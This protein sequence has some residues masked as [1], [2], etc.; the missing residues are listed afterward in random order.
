MSKE[1]Q[2]LRTKAISNIVTRDV[3]RDVQM[4]TLERIAMALKNSYGPDGSTTTLRVGDDTKNTGITGYTK[5]GHRILSNIRFSKPIEFSIV[6]DLKD[7]TRNTVKNV[8]DGTTSAVLMSYYIFKYLK[9]A[10]ETYNIPE[11]KLAD[12]LLKASKEICKIIAQN[13]RDTTLDDIY[14]IAYTS[15]DGNEEIANNIKELYEKFGM[16]AY[17][18]VGV[19]NT[20][21]DI[22]RKYDGLTIDAGYFNTDF[23]NNPKDGTFEARNV[24]IYIF[25]DPIDTVEMM[26]LLG[27][28]LNKNILDPCS[29]NDAKALVPTVVFCPAFGND[30]RSYIDNYLS[31]LAT[32]DSSN[33]PPFLIVPNVHSIESLYDLAKLSGATI[34]KK[35][36]DPEVQKKDIQQGLA[37]T[38]ETVYKFAGKADAVTA[39]AKTT[40]IIGPEKMFEESPFTH[41]VTRSKLYNDMIESLEAKLRQ[42]ETEKTDIVELH[43]L[44]I[45]IQSLKCNL[46]DYYIG[47]I[48]YTD[49]DAIKDAVEDAVLNCRN[50]AKYGVGNGANFEGFR[51]ANELAS[52]FSKEH[53]DEYNIYDTIAKA[54]CD[55]VSAIYEEYA[56]THKDENGK[57]F[58]PKD[59]AISC[60]LHGKPFDLRN[61]EFSDHILTSIKA[62][63]VVLDAISKIIGLM[64]KTNQYIVATPSIN[65]YEIC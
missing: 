33:K 2:V 10:H 7:I 31:Y 47:G 3:L 39:D 52:K 30:I 50:A 13:G 26:S 25:E 14:W 23:I 64:F 16:E 35:Y 44:R 63:Q 54:Y 49:R 62:D 20:E 19:S 11:K 8:G 38:V 12:E 65:T 53:P 56:H 24:S 48:S 57:T 29:K 21:N 4:E 32:A 37:P 1:S 46:V 34:I 28:I 36:I 41:E 22:I 55:L 27:S 40:K 60:L 43:K 59:V 51:A 18:N 42:L 6:D 9:E 5:D 17:I 61:E 45:R 15:T 58:E